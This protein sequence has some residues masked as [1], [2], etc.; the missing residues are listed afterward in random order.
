MAYLLASLGILATWFIYRQNI[1]DEKNKILNSLDAVLDYSGQWFNA[2]YP[3]ERNNPGWFNPGYSVYKVD[4]SILN[5]IVNNNTVSKE[6]SKLLAYFVQLV[7]RFNQRVDLFNQFIYSN[8]F[9]LKE[10]TKFHKKNCFCDKNYDECKKVIESLNEKDENFK[11]YVKRIYSLQKS[12][13]V[14]GIGT[15]EYYSMELPQL[16]LC[17]RKLK[18]QLS[19]ERKNEIRFFH[20]KKYVL[21]DIA[22]III[23]ASI[24]LARIFIFFD[25]IKI[26]IFFK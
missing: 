21:G 9:L 22:F 15:Q 26:L 12:I 11:F 3:K 5:N 14:D 13:H 6:I 16:S 17:Y 1:I 8:E 7:A 23:P 2:S 4:V 20:D 19:I 18:E 10:A 24:I 25:S